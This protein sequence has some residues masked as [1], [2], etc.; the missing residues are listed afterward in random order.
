MAPSFDEREQ[1]SSPAEEVDEA[2]NSTSENEDDEIDESL[3]PLQNK[4]LIRLVRTNAGAELYV[5]S[6]AQS[7]LAQGNWGNLLAA[8][9]DALG[10]LG[11]CFVIASDPIGALCV[12]EG[13]DLRYPSLRANLVH[14]SNLGRGAF[15]DAETRLKSVSTVAHAICEPG[16][17]V[18]LP[19]SV[20]NLVLEQMALPE[21][22]TKRPPD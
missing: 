17:V 13:P 8:A 10:R 14:C 6:V 7:A 15:R 5:T 1:E 2:M 12:L 9:P 4:E 20:F 11:Q 16:G 22:R 19:I 3:D 21:L 18:S